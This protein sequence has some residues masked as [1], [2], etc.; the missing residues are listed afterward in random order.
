MRVP[1]G[2]LVR[3]IVHLPLLCDER[4]SAPTDKFAEVRPYRSAF[5]AASRWS[6]QHMAPRL[7]GFYPMAAKDAA[8]VFTGLQMEG[9]LGDFG[10]PDVRRWRAAYMQFASFPRAAGAP[11]FYGPT[12][13]FA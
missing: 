11:R 3:N 13:P 1:H 5:A 4:A 8:V 9:V 6:S 12:L 10:W 7:L 2:G